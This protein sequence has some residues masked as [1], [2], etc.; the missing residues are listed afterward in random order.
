MPILMP[1]HIFYSPKDIASTSMLRASISS[2]VQSSGSRWLWVHALLIWWVSIT[3]TCTVLWITWGGLAYRRREI[4][5]LAAKVQKERAS[6]RVA[7]GG[8]EGMAVLEDCEGIKRFRTVMVLNIPPDM[9]DENVLQDY[10]DHY[11]DK[12]HQ[13]KQGPSKR[14]PLAKMFRQ[15]IPIGQNPSYSVDVGP[16]EKSSVEDIVLVRKL[17]V[18][19]NLRSRREEVL[20]KLEIA[21]TE[22]AKRVLADVAK[23]YKRPKALYSIKDPARAARMSIL[24]E[25]LGRF[26]EPKSP[27]GD[28]TV[29]DVSYPSSVF[30]APNVVSILGTSLG[31]SRMSR[32][33]PSHDPLQ[34]VIHLARP[35]PASDRL[36]HHQTRLPHPSPHRIPLQTARILRYRLYRLCH[37]SR[38]QNGEVGVENS[39]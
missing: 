34:T 7:S 32:P 17:G 28:K 24:V 16:S 18:L 35:K 11:I 22:L 19:I 14:K 13:R 15:A 21:H 30:T 38:R 23:Y 31:S 27:H 1:L 29:W 6:K 4:R 26:T 36:P 39:G 33:I 8:E 9:R 25:K 3:W 37:F 10:F 12:Y 20:K 2:L 5:A